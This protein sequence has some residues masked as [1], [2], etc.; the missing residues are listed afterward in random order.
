MNL[1]NSIQCINA[2]T[3]AVVAAAGLLLFIPTGCISVSE[4]SEHQNNL[5]APSWEGLYSA[6]AVINPTA[7]NSTQGWVR[8]QQTTAGIRV[9][10]EISGLPANTTHGF[11]IH[12]FGDLTRTDGK[13]AG[14][15]YNPQG[16][17]HALPNG[18]MSHAG[19]MGNL[20]ANAQGIA[21]Y[22][23]FLPNITIAGTHNPILG[24][25]VIVHALEDDGGQPTGNAGARV[26]Y[27]VIGIANDTT[28]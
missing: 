14:G 25:G 19:D 22:E 18:K 1:R 2:P 3:L 23:R 4:S 15:H 13:S 16:H 24:R 5:I 17:D 27:G 8:F 9:T 28:P 6:V 7:G 10:A 12:Q 21:S 26:G 20:I 11:H